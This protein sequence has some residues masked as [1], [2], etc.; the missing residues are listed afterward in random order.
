MCLADI[1]KLC[2]LFISVQT[3]GPGWLFLGRISSWHLLLLCLLL[4]WGAIWAETLY[5]MQ[6]GN[7]SFFFSPFC[8][9]INLSTPFY[10][11]IISNAYIFYLLWVICGLGWVAPTSMFHTFIL[12]WL[13][14]FWFLLQI[15]KNEYTAIHSCSNIFLKLSALSFSFFEFPLRKSVRFISGW[16]FLHGSSR[17]HCS[18]ISHSN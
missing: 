6:L 18:W 10:E 13:E 2:R 7:T 8:Q 1:A 9:P 17:I 16:I 11:L 4:L 5:V 14:I 15:C 12:Q 3:H